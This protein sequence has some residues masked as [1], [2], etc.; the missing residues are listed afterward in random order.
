[1]KRKTDQSLMRELV[2]LEDDFAE[3][4]CVSAFVLAA[5]PAVMSCDDAQQP[6][7]VAGA[8][9]CADMIQAR[10]KELK[11]RLDRACERYRDEHTKA[12][13]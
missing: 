8:K 2:L 9:L 12:A 5:L 10:T 6:E 13:D 3:H 1:M 4:V 11:Q 7:V